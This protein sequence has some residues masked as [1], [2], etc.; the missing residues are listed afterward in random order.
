ML[1][2]LSALEEANEDPALLSTTVV[3]C[4]AGLFFHQ[5]AD[6]GH[7]PIEAQK[8]MRSFLTIAALLAA[9]CSTPDPLEKS[10]FGD[11]EEIG[12]DTG[13]EDRG[14]EIDT[15]DTAA[16]CEFEV[17]TNEGTAV[18]ANTVTIS[19]AQ[20][21]DSGSQ[22]VSEDIRAL[23]IQVDADDEECANLT[24]QSLRLLVVWADKAD[25]DWQPSGFYAG[26]S[27]GMTYE[28]EVSDMGGL[29]F[30][31][32][33]LDT[34]I[35]AGDYGLIGFH[36]DVTGASAENDDTIRVDLY[37]DTIVVDDGET[38]A[39]LAH[40]GINGDTIVF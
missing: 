28:G 8:T 31:D 3:M 35:V 33:D 17:E 9:G 4:S 30:V 16:L 27:A 39:T 40:E 19:Q 18:M 20:G 34:Q 24:V 1:Y 23:V 6:P 32:F 26:D 15:A 38:N 12:C 13:T 21:A 2:Y 36:V 29:I 14:I 22:E 10:P 5:L 25:T 11:S 37:P 7:S